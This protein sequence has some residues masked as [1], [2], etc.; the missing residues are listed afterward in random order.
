MAKKISNVINSYDI[1]RL[2]LEQSYRAHVGHIGC[3]LSIADILVSLYDKV[4]KLENFSDPLRDRFVLSK[5]HAAL[6][7]FS[8]LF[9][10]GMITAEQLSSFH[11]DNSYLGV[12]PE[13]G[14]PGV[15]L[16]TGSL[17]QGLS[18]GAGMA[19]AA[20]LK[21]E[22]WRTFVLLSDAEC[23]EGSVWEAA[24]FSSQHQLSNLTAIIDFNKQQGFGYTKDVIS[25]RQ[26][27]QKWKA[28]GWQVDEVDG[29]NPTAVT[30]VLNSPTKNK[31]HLVLAHTSLGK[32]VSFMERLVDWHYL[33]LGQEQYTQALQE[34]EVFKNGKQS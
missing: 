2:I 25:T 28:F 11:G 5:G 17:G 22:K 20:K 10:K 30:K 33:P 8:I 32:G 9:L 6:A 1:R 31:P 23:N 21:K 7:L 15:E 16:A 29:H 24:A 13:Y 34:I 4:L 3:C 18:S 12:H 19:L 14:L 27:G 26:L